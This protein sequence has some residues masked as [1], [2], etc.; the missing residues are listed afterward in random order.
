[1]EQSDLIELLA[2]RAIEFLRH[3]DANPNVGMGMFINQAI[4]LAEESIAKE[5]ARWNALE[6]LR[7]DKAFTLEVEG[8]AYEIIKKK[9]QG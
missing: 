2:E 3:D 9:R 4:E 7:I 8:K 5:A 6:A 1:M